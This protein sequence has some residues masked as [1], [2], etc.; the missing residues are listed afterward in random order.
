MRVLPLYCYFPKSEWEHIRR[1]EIDDALGNK[2]LSDYST[3]YRHE[4]LKEN[5]DRKI[6]ESTVVGSLA[7]RASPKDSIRHTVV[8]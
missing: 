4:F 5:Q 3:I 2:I 7:C 1:A 6:I 8:S